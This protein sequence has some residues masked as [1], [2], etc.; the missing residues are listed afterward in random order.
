MHGYRQIAVRCVVVC[1]LGLRWS[2]GA[3]TS[4]FDGTQDLGK[5]QTKGAVA[6]DADRRHGDTG[7]ALRIEPGASACWKLRDEDGSGRVSLWVYDDGTAPAD[8]KA[9]RTGPRWGVALAG[10]RVLAVGALYARYL[11]GDTTYAV[12]DT[13][14]KNWFANLQYL[15]I[16]REARWR[17]WTF[18]FDAEKGMT[19]ML[20]DQP[21]K[22]F[23]W[24]K[25]NA[26]G[27]AA[28]ALFGDATDGK[29]QTLW[30]DDVEAELGGP[31]KVKPTPPPPPPPVVPDKDPALEGPP[32]AW[33]EGM[34][35]K[36]PRLLLTA[37]R[38]PQLKAFFQPPAG[39]QPTGGS[40]LAKPWRDQMLAYLPVCVAPEKPAFLADA[41]D[42]QRQ[43]LWR[44]P[45]VALHYLLTGDK[46]SLERG[47][48]FL[49]LLQSLPD[50]ETGEERNS[51]MSAANIMVGAALTFDWLHN[52]LDPAFREQFRKTLW[53][54]ARAMYHGGHLAKN[55]GTHYWQGDPQNNH[56]WHRNAGLALAVLAA[57]SGA[58]DEQWLLARTHEEL[59]FV[60]K[61][62]PR[63][64][65]S[66]E[67]ATYLVFGGP[68]LVLACQA[69]DECLGTKYLDE[70]FFR[71]VG[72]FRLSTL[73]PG[74]RDSLHYG[75]SGG[76]GG[77]NNFLQK[78]AAHH[79]QADVM[80]GLRQFAKAEPKATEFGW[81]SILWDD[82]SLT[83]GQLGK[84][85]TASFFPDLGLATVRESWGDGAVAAMFKCGPFGGYRLNEYRNGRNFQYINVAHDD[86]DAN[87]FVLLAGGEYLAE[88]DRYSSAKRSS[89]HN[90]ILVNGMGQM[91]P[92]R[93]EPQGWTQPGSGDMTQ[94]AKVTAWFV[95]GTSPSRDTRREDT[96]PTIVV[97][98]GEAAGSYLAYT[99]R[100][101]KKSRPALD[102]FR[103]TFIWVKGSYVLVLDDI[104][105]PQAV[106]ITWLVQGPKLEAVDAA[107]GR[108]R[109][110]ASKAQ[111]DFQVVADAAFKADVAVST[112]DNRSK[113]LGW[114]QLQASLNTAAVRFASVYDPW[115]HKDLAVKLDGTTVTVRSGKFTDTWQWTPAGGR[116]EASSLRGTR[117][118]GFDVAIDSKAA[119]PPE[120]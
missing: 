78:A 17:K 13:D 21:V 1:L 3:A 105:A 92:G 80:D 8:P 52:D 84:L 35:A 61:W 69:S 72:L 88:T 115:Q 89:N 27:F 14:Q 41:T 49:K 18:D 26:T 33:R 98:E 37:E 96:P 10:G 81:W 20:D 47:I 6:L 51:G 87:S 7:S 34:L 44:M 36:R 83:G 62:L 45:T 29:A 68:H 106:D 97:V 19:L 22:R 75:D 116:F 118:G 91:V 28:V 67:S 99:D 65:T 59:G 103:R 70:P 77:Y 82:P 71:N 79:K 60:A 114:Q 11:A 5:W 108:Y 100:K 90:T 4:S 24:N 85:P 42:G 46:A 107:N 93:A 56:R 112:A 73:A 39:S 120:P 31:M 109:L 76:V 74:L 102:R 32:V 15:G 9:Y 95:G 25:T 16:K 12:T 53:F 117:P 66:H 113:P 64:G 119:A 54:H 101:T 23:D 48:G 86:P 57:F 38:I 111:C 2:Q 40:D 63:D 110:V 30:V 94:M 43:G 58:D 55:P 50:W 104:R